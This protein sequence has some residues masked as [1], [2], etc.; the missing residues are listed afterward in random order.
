MSL[1]NCAR[2]VLL[3]LVMP[4]LLWN[5]TSTVNQSTKPV[6]SAAEDAPPVLAST[7]TST[8]DYHISS[9]DILEISVFQ[10]KDL[11]KS[12]QVGDDGNIAFPL[13]GAVQVKGKTTQ[14][15]ADIIAAKLAKKYLQSPQVSVFVKQY[16]QRVTV[17]GEVR[18]PRVL[19]VE[20]DLT[21]SQVIA[22]AGGLSDL[23]DG[24]RIHIVRAA[25]G[26]VKDEVYSLNAIQA[27]KTPD[28]RL[29]GGDLVVAEQSGAQ[30]AFKNLKDMLPFAVL[31]S[32]L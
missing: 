3:A 2:I 22:S 4:L 14:E 15:A 7:G 30:V 8:S 26:H 6:A 31:A 10:V 1:R 19:A 17:N 16:G 24:N 11:D 29:Q 5:C 25:G 9:R 28:P 23:A 20:G 12:V 18:N 21:L 27:G 13:I 32:V